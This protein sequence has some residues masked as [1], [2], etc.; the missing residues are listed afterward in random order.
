MR[1]LLVTLFIVVSLFVVSGFSSGS[2]AAPTA[3]TPC[4]AA[5]S[6]TYHHVIVWMLENHSL[7][8][9]RGFMPYLDNL[10]DG[11]A[12]TTH[13]TAIT[14]PSL[15]NY[16]ADV[17]GKTFGITDDG[18]PAQHPLSGA[19]IFTQL[20]G[21][22][23]GFHDG[24]TKNCMLVNGGDHYIVHHNP[25]AYFT[26]M[27]TACNNRDKPYTAFAAAL[28]DPATEPAYMLVVP[29]NCHNGH[30]NSCGGTKI[31]DR[32]VLAKQAD[33]YLAA[34][35][36]A[37]LNSPAYQAGDTLIEITFDEGTGGGQTVYT[38]LVA[39]GVTPGTVIPTTLTAYSLLK[40][41]ESSLGVACLAAACTA[42]ALVIP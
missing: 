16:L 23:N 11:C 17:A 4:V 7:S 20:P 5:P 38:V 32:A 13:L 25:A 15:P 26:N 37:V 1:K 21:K 3:D 34:Q 27:R 41:N 24:M 30:P 31:T 33:D 19:S 2:G 10:A 36:P 12:Y 40:Y 6:N 18:T 28:S 29:N 22:W 14:H 8:N 42:P 9:S 35:L 39:P